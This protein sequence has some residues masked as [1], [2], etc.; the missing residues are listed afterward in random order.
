[1][2]IYG[3]NASSSGR[4]L[5]GEGVPLSTALR[6]VKNCGRYSEANKRQGTLRAGKKLSKENM[7]GRSLTATGFYNSQTTEITALGLKWLLHLNRST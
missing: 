2:S 3:E 6:H 5:L 1:M 4:I 7:G